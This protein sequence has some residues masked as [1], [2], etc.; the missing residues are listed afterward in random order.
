MSTT[1]SNKHARMEQAA[2]VLS[3]VVA[4]SLLILKFSAFLITGSVAIFSDAVE[5]IV[6]VVAAGFA[7]YAIK[8]AQVPADE[9]HPYGHG[10]IEFLAAAFEGGMIAL[11]AVFIAW[12]AVDNLFLNPSTPGNLVIGLALS[13]IAIF[14]NGGVAFLLLRRARRT[15]SMVLEADGMHLLSDVIS[16]V[17]VIVALALVKLTGWAWIDPIVAMLIAGYIAWMGFRLVRNAAGHLMDKQDEEDTKLLESILNA[18]VG[19]DGQEPQICSWHKLRHRH[20]GRY[21]WVD[22][23]VV[24]PDHLDV[25]AGH[26]I[27]SQIENEMQRALGNG[28]ATAHIE[29]CTDSNC[30]RCRRA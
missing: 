19:A 28:N 13:A 17:A 5:S 9:D 20:S 4:I 26:N 11:A 12:Q 8:R 7:L 16:S 1:P 3:L 30:S 27:A 25:R 10:K 2:A 14:V 24:V 21:H 22:F 23:H 18:H 15:G 6:N 29:P